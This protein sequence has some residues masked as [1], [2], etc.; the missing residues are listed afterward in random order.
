MNMYISL[1]KS[2]WTFC[3]PAA[4]LWHASKVPFPYPLLK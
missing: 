1:L 4:T 2:R 3:L